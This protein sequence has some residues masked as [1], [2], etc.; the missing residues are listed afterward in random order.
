MQRSKYHVIS[1]DYVECTRPTAATPVPSSVSV[2]QS[3]PALGVNSHTS[4]AGPCCNGGGGSGSGSIS[5]RALSAPPVEIGKVVL[6]RMELKS[7]LTI[8]QGSAVP[9]EH[10]YNH[11]QHHQYQ[12]QQQQQQSSTPPVYTNGESGR[13]LTQTPQP[14]HEVPI[15]SVYL[16]RT[17]SDRP[18][19]QQQQQQQQ[20]L[21]PLATNGYETDSGLANSSYNSNSA[22]PAAGSKVTYRTM[23]A[24]EASRFRQLQQ[25]QQQQ[26]QQ[27]MQTNG[28]EA[29]TRQL[30][31]S[32]SKRNV[33]AYIGANNFATIS[34]HTPKHHHHHHHHQHHVNGGARSVTPSSY[35]NNN[36][37]YKHQTPTP[38]RHR[39]HTPHIDM[40]ASSSPAVAVG[41]EDASAASTSPMHQHLNTIQ[42]I[43][44]NGNV[45]SGIAALVSS[46]GNQLI[47]QELDP[48]SLVAA[49][50]NNNNNVGVDTTNNVNDTNNHLSYQHHHHNAG[51]QHQPLHQQLQQ[52]QMTSS[53]YHNG[54]NTN[55]NIVDS[56]R[57]QQQQQ[58][59]R[60]TETASSALHM[61][62]VSLNQLAASNTTK[63]INAGRVGS[64]SSHLNLTPPKQQQQQQQQTPKTSKEATT[65]TTATAST[66]SQVN[67]NEILRAHPKSVKASQA[68]W[69]KPKI[70]RDDAIALIRDKPPGTFLIR[71]SNNFPGAYGLAVKV[72]KPPANV[73][74]KRGADPANELVRHFLIE[75][76]N[77]ATAA[78]N[79]TTA[80]AANT[81]TSGVR[82]K[83]CCN[84]PIFGSLAALV[85]QHSIVALALPIKLVLPTKDLAE[86][87]NANETTTTTTNNNNNS[88]S[89][90]DNQ[91]AAAAAKRVESP[92]TVASP[93]R[94]ATTTTTTSNAESATVNGSGET[95]DRNLSSLPA[96]A[97]QLLEKGAGKL[98]RLATILSVVKWLTSFM[99][100]LCC[101]VFSACNVYY[102]NAA[103]IDSRS[104]MDGIRF[105][106]QCTRAF[107]DKD[108]SQLLLIQFKVTSQGITLTDL[109][110]KRFSRQHFPVNTVFY[111]A[112][113]EQ[114]VWP[115]KLDKIAKPRS[116]FLSF[117]FN[118]LFCLSHSK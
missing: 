75:P 50:V 109:A 110:K 25:Q 45:T 36:Y 27:Q 47:I 23:D 3:R 89:R 28:Y 4:A 103:N 93:T 100:V 54:N 18:T 37:A 66:Q 11:H 24:A 39:T 15:R 53:V 10:N 96:E 97:R 98:I 41:C 12:Q 61:N 19:Q 104:G 9:F 48:S 99:F 70:S 95:S 49:A 115:H 72:D 1:N 44:A 2:Y 90:E 81:A 52:Q 69:Y 74:L 30:P 114:L 68:F 118:V 76:T 67:L 86:F 91:T 77:L 6:Q 94:A 108:S 117:K 59:S 38:S 80:A 42:Y 111:C 35:N 71:D 26:Q 14:H 58:Q 51:Y 62:S 5:K 73:Q 34:N 116:L 20:Q 88:S 113:D 112:V 60:D 63:E 7:P 31:F 56:S 83:G 82:I 84:E 16:N 46:V 13:H 85:Y 33:N 29:D 78:A 21:A 92:A 40:M 17:H 22:A 106:L 57:Q 32:G 107:M 55:N 102:L 79:K 87:C 43:D 8:R 101:F 105:A 65:T 64:S